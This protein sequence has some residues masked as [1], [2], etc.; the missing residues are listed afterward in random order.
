LEKLTKAVN[1]SKSRLRTLFKAGIGITP[2]QYL[3]QI[4]MKYAKELAEKSNLAIGEIM[5]SIGVSDESHFRRDFKNAYGITLTE[6][7]N[8][9]YQQIKDEQQSQ[10]FMMKINPQSNRPENSQIGQ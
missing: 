8:V 3:K 7:R 5:A 10:K 2:A 4:K 9:Y 6:C 1:L